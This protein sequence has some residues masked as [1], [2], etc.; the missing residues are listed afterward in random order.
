MKLF[1]ICGLTILLAAASAP[2]AKADGVDTFSYQAAGTTFTWQLPNSPTPTGPD[3]YPGW[4]FTLENIPVSVNGAAPVLGSFDFFS[5]ACSGGFDLSIGSNVPA[6]AYGPMLYMG[7]ESAPTFLPGKF[8][9][10][11]YG[12]SNNGVSGTLA[13]TNVPE[14]SS[15]G[16]LA[17]GLLIF[18][19]GFAGKKANSQLS[20][21]TSQA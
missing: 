18:A 3:V 19:V 13:I 16:L 10:T 20:D 5:N 15:L 2:L 21:S 8:S 4:G 6:D 14:P 1:G 9:F 7:P 17:I 11:D 12:S